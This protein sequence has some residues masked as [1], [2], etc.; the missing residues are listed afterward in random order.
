MSVKGEDVCFKAQKISWRSD[1]GTLYT[2]QIPRTGS[3]DDRPS[4][5]RGVSGLR[6]GKLQTFHSSITKA[7]SWTLS[8]GRKATR[9]LYTAPS[10]RITTSPNPPVPG[11]KTPSR[12]GCQLSHRNHI[13]MWS[14]EESRRPIEGR[15][16]ARCVAMRFRS[17]YLDEYSNA[18]REHRS[19]GR[20][21]WNV[22]GGSISDLAQGRPDPCLGTNVSDP[23]AFRC[24]DACCLALP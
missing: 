4:A 13:P 11:L 16:S 12:D 2:P 24:R 21:S 8:S 23:L 15:N 10:R 14:V 18:T 22:R 9:R 1:G 3:R 5:S 19:I 17:R 20:H 7:P 6:V